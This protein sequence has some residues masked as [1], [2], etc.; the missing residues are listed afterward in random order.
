MFLWGICCNIHVNT[1]LPSCSVHLV[2]FTT[3][4]SSAWLFESLKFLLLLPV[5]TMQEVNDLFVNGFAFQARLVPAHN[6]HFSQQ[7]ILA[8]K[9]KSGRQY[10]LHWKHPA[11]LQMW[12]QLQDRG[13][14]T[15]VLS[16]P[17]TPASADHRGRRKALGERLDFP[18]SWGM[19]M[20]LPLAGAD[21]KRLQSTPGFLRLEHL[22]EEQKL[23]SQ[24]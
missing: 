4:F 1:E 6:T 8:P 18:K 22:A 3:S 2:L 20:D 23:P 10:W 24:S 16:P 19:F 15:L 13:N 9:Y 11:E 21:V 12:K 17:S 7:E 14:L 5:L